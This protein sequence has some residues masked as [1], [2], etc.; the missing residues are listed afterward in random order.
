MR[1]LDLDIRAMILA[2]LIVAGLIIACG[3]VA[4]ACLPDRSVDEVRTAAEEAAWRAWSV[5]HCHLVTRAM[6]TSDLPAREAWECDDGLTYWR[7]AGPVAAPVP[8]QPGGGVG[9][10]GGR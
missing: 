8:W 1:D 9:T 7:D 2:V 4:R 5:G 6:R 3:L 10:G